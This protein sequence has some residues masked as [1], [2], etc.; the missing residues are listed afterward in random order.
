MYNPL[1]GVSCGQPLGG[2]SCGHPLG[3]VSCVQPS[4]R[5]ELW[6]ASRR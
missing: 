4:R 2:V 6:T 5:C 1:G 3:G